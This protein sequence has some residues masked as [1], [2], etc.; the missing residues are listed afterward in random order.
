VA[1]VVVIDVIAIVDIDG[2]E[3]AVVVKLSSFPYA[4]PALFVA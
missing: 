4:V 1:V 2:S 3:T